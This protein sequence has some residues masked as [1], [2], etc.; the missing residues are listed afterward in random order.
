M[1]ADSWEKY[2]IRREKDPG[3]RI[4]PWHSHCFVKTTYTRCKAQHGIM[5][6]VNSA[7]YY[8]MVSYNHHIRMISFVQLPIDCSCLY[9]LL[10]ECLGHEV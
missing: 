6:A 1:S 5:K 2:G 7:F 8:F 3:A 10:D 9:Y 4:A